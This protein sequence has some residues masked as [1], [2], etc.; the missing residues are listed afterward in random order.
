M[1]GPT[2][3]AFTVKSV[4]VTREHCLYWSNALIKQIYRLNRALRRQLSCGFGLRRIWRQGQHGALRHLLGG[5]TKVVTLTRL[6]SHTQ[7]HTISSCSIPK[8][9]QKANTKAYLGPIRIE[10]A[11]SQR[12]CIR[13]CACVHAFCV[14]RECFR[15]CVCTSV[16][17]KSVLRPLLTKRKQPE[18]YLLGVLYSTSTGYLHLAQEVG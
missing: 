14:A 1:I 3:V 13:V 5:K 7:V 16:C 8:G 17:L 18:W 10:F 6:E 11:F 12:A 15:E 2:Y 9:N 4:S